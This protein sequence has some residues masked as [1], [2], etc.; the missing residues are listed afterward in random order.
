MRLQSSAN[1]LFMSDVQNLTQGCDN[2]PLLNPAI[3]IG[4]QAFCTVLLTI[5]NFRRHTPAFDQPPRQRCADGH[6][7]VGG[8]AGIGGGQDLVGRADLWLAH[9]D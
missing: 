3:R 5:D 1:R 4:S 7:Q 9:V 2:S 8:A 6:G